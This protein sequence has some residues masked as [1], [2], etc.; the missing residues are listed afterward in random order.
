VSS[1]ML[2]AEQKPNIFTFLMLPWQC[3]S[4]CLICESSAEI[5]S[6]L[7]RVCDTCNHR[8]NRYTC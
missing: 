7:T 4:I 2:F 3:S 1:T 8:N 5:K 6:C